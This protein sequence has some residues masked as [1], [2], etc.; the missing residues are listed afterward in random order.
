MP[1]LSAV[2]KDRRVV[3]ETTSDKSKKSKDDDEGD[4][5]ANVEANEI[6]RLEREGVGEG[7]ASSDEEEL[8]DDADATETRKR[9]R[10]MDE[11]NSQSWSNL[12]RMWVVFIKALTLKNRIYS[13]IGAKV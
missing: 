2:M 1:V 3:V 4:D 11:V 12:T 13:A 10:Q 9:N 8:A 7:H 6:D 5:N